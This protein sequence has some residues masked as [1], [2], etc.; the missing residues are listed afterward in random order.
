MTK[1]DIFR[2]VFRVGSHSSNQSHGC[3]HET[4]KCMDEYAKQEAIA[5]MKFI[6]KQFEV[7]LFIE[8]DEELYSI[9]QQSKE[10]GETK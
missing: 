5:A 9:F 4:L 2:K 1:D 7:E 8:T 3:Y 10:K 6:A